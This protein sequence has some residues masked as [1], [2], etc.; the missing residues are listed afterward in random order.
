VI[1]NPDIRELTGVNF[2]LDSSHPI[3]TQVQYGY[4][5]STEETYAWYVRVA[6]FARLLTSLTPILE[7]RVHHSLM[8]GYTGTVH[9]SCYGSG[10]ILEWQDGRLSAVRNTRPPIMGEGADACL[11]YDTFLMLLFGRKSLTDIRF[12]HHE[13]HASTEAT[14]LLDILFPKNPSWFQW[15]N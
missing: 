14:Q 12:W 15:M 2:V 8:V 3:Y 13:A 9:I 5:I 7:A 10:V 4:T 11:P 6:D 1:T